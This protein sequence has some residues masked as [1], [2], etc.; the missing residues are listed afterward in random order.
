MGFDLSPPNTPASFARLIAS[1]LA[2]WVPIVKASG[3]K[4]D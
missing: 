2:H 4:A 1:D 3:A